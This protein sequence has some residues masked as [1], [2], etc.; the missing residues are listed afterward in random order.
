MTEGESLRVEKLPGEPGSSLD[1]AEVLLVGDAGSVRVGRPLLSD[2]KV[3]AQ[4]VRH[5]KGNKITVYKF[6]KRKGWRL[7]HGHR[8]EYTELK[9]TGIKG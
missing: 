7:R 6:R 8:Q 9:I 3:T 5:D 1:L 4:I 2:V